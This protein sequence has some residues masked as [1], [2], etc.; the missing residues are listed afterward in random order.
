[1]GAHLRRP[2]PRHR[3]GCSRW[4]SSPRSS[5]RARGRRSDARRGGALTIWRDGA[6]ERLKSGLPARPGGGSLSAT[7]AIPVRGRRRGRPHGLPRR[8]AASLLPRAAR[9]PGE[10][11]HRDPSSGS[12][13]E[14]AADRPVTGGDVRFEVVAFEV[15]PEDF[16]S[17]LSSEATLLTSLGGGD[18]LPPSVRSN[19]GARFGRT[20]ADASE[21][22]RRLDAGEFGRSQRLGDLVSALSPGTTASFIAA[23]RLT[24]DLSQVRGPVRERLEMRVALDSASRLRLALV[25]VD[26]DNGPPELPALEGSPPPAAPA[27]ARILYTETAYFEVEPEG[28]RHAAILLS[29]S[30]F[31][32]HEGVALGLIVEADVSPAA[33]GAFAMD[34]PPGLSA[35]A[36]I[37]EPAWPGL[38]SAIEALARADRQRSALAFLARETGATL[39]YDASLSLDDEL[40]GSLAG[41]ICEAAAALPAPHDAPTAGWL[42]ERETYLYL[43]ET[44]D[45][46]ETVGSQARGLLLAHAGE[47]GRYPS[48][49]REVVTAAKDQESL[50]AALRHE[51]LLFLEDNSPS[52]RVRAFDWLAQ[53]GQVIEGYDPLGPRK[54]RRDALRRAADAAPEEPKGDGRGEHRRGG[55]GPSGAPEEAPALAA[56]DRRVLPDRLP[57]PPRGPDRP[58]VPAA[59]HP[60]RGAEVEPPARGLRTPRPEP[61]RRRGGALAREAPARRG[62]RAVRRARALPGGPRGPGA[63]PR[64]RRRPARGGGRARPAARPWGGRPDRASEASRNRRVGEARGA[65]ARARGRADPLLASGGDRRRRA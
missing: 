3:W 27:D 11:L 25:L 21:F 59:R 56:A 9:L 28:G 4:P 5:P 12:R 19:K 65:R 34:K 22:R 37:D 47:I 48:S 32:E 29:M 60:E 10:R 16:L 53:R 18:S 43:L 63:V 1:M 31:D 6:R 42:V 39:A 15:L 24:Q 26:V 52:S 61:P 14:P 35:G 20:P 17:P 36:P 44:S 41:R 7:Y 58:A 57:P 38:G 64:E 23:S 54:E 33:A 51:N 2:V 45:R 49:L 55:G 46:A 50:A 13:G 40:L 8:R 30:P 62:R